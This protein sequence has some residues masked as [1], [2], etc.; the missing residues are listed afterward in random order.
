MAV[1]EVTKCFECAYFS[2]Y[3]SKVAEWTT[4]QEEKHNLTY[5]IIPIWNGMSFLG[6]AALDENQFD[7]YSKF[8]AV[9]SPVI[10]FYD[11]AAE[12]DI[13]PDRKGMT[14]WGK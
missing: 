3:R 11:K 10:G 8:F 2:G 7:Y 6:F 12:W 4:A 1:V 9:E 13:P 5:E 14:L